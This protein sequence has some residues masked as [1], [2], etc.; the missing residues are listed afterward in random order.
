MLAIRRAKLMSEGNL[1]A[2]MKDWLG[3][4]RLS[5]SCMRNSGLKFTLHSDQGNCSR[6]KTPNNSYHNGSFEHRVP[7]LGRFYTTGSKPLKFG[8][9]RLERGRGFAKRFSRRAHPDIDSLDI[10]RLR[11]V[12]PGGSLIS[13]KHISHILPTVYKPPRAT[14]M[15]S[16]V[17]GTIFFA[18]GNK[19]KI[20]EV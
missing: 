3:A 4:S 20:K 15:A 7:S 1:K 19:N 17:Q 11:P 6:S 8:Q 13:F 16:Q 10:P 5:R 14:G 12:S 18:T 2:R 9:E